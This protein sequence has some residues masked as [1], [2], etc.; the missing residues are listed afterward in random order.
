MQFLIDGY[1]LLFFYLTPDEDLKKNR[2]ELISVLDKKLKSL[3]I[4]ATI[5]F[6]GFSQINKDAEHQ[7][8][9]SLTVV[10]SPKAQTADEYIIERLTSSKNPNEITIITADKQLASEARCLKAHSKT[11]K[12]FLKEIA[13]KQ[14]AIENSTE[15]EQR[16]F[17]ESKAH[18]ER[19]VK[20]FEKRL[21]DTELE[22]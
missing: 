1:N 11:P 5:V 7:Y 18:I 17:E 13:T 12:A 15:K 22:I 20:L 21:Q 3:N 4:K 19:L 10:F 14:A 6:D 9:E 8:F 16:D 2:E